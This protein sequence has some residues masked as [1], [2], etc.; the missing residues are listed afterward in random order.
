MFELGGGFSDTVISWLTTGGFRIVV[1]LFVTFLFRKFSGLFVEKMIRKVIVSDRF[2]SKEAERKREDTLIKIINGAISV[3][4]LLVAILMILGELG[5]EIGPVLAAAGIVGLAFG[6]GGQY[7]IRDIISGLFITLENQY[8]VGDVVCFD[9]TCGVVE[10]I[11]L[12]KTALRDMNGT[13]HHVPH[14]EI[15]QVSN[16]TKDYAKINLDVGV[17][18]D[19]DLDEV[20]TIVDRVGKELAGD[21]EWQESII[22]PPAFLRVNDLGDS[23]ITVK[24]TGETKP[25]KQ[26]AVTGEL[27]KRLKLAFDKAGIEIPFP[28]R[29]IHKAKD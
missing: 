7:L 1:I 25:A 18:Y 3:I 16:L 2:S 8:R 22:S 13:L 4:V 19:S 15:K 9:K 27:R 29:V 17:A 10:D 28:Q 11:T 20:L 26:W 6:F 12:R 21:P 24:I 23:A 5:I 14:G